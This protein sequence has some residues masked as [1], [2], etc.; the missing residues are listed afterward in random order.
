M[1]SGLTVD[2]IRWALILSCFDSLAIDVS[3][4]LLEQRLSSV[5]QWHFPFQ[6][7]IRGRLLERKVPASPPES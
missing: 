7:L 4:H 3:P 2:N 5:F 1:E 6:Y